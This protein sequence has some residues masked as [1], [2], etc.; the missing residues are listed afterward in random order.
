[1]LKTNLVIKVLS[2]NL[3]TTYLYGAKYIKHITHG[4]V[5][6]AQ[7]T[8]YPRNSKYWQKQNTTSQSSSGKS[9]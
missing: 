2:G 1:M 6:V 5:E 7:K 9:L 3:V 8:E 4:Y